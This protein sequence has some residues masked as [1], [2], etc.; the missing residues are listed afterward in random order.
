MK[1]LKNKIQSKRGIALASAMLFMVAIFSL[2]ILLT[3]LATLGHYT[4]KLERVKTNRTVE[5]DRI[6]EDY[7]AEGLEYVK[8]CYV[9]K[10][11]TFEEGTNAENKTLTVKH[12]RASAVVL[13]VELDEGGNVC[14]WQYSLP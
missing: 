4:L 9:E 12:G 11:Y 1:K 7:V 5:I 8:A 2:C 10:G 6:G 13:Y 14:R 3:S